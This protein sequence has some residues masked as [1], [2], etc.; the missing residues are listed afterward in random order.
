MIVFIAGG[1]RVSIVR[2]L[3]SYES[4]LD[5]LLQLEDTDDFELHSA[6]RYSA[7]IFLPLAVCFTLVLR[8]PKPI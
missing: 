4:R 3:V 2:D 1:F 5:I 6:P 7:Y 8:S